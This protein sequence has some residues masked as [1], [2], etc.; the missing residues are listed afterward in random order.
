MLRTAV[1][2][3][4]LT[5]ASGAF[6]QSTS[7][8]LD[9]GGGMSHVDTMGPNGAMT[10]SN[11]MNIGGGIATCN[12]LDLSRPRRNNPTPDA[13][14][15][16]TDRPTLNFIGDLIARTKERSFQKKVSKMIADGDC[17]GAATFALFS[18]RDALSDQIHRDCLAKAYAEASKDL[19]TGATPAPEI[20]ANKQMIAGTPMTPVSG[21]ST[22]P[23]P[24][25]PMSLVSVRPIPIPDWVK[26]RDRVKASSDKTASVDKD[27]TGTE[28][29]VNYLGHT[30]LLDGPN[31]MTMGDIRS[32]FEN[33]WNDDPWIEYTSSGSGSIYSYNIKSAKHYSDHK[34]V[35]IKIDHSKDR[36]TKARTSKILY[37]I[38]CGKQT[39]RELQS[40][41]ND[42]SGIVLSL[43]NTPG[44]SNRIVPET[45]GSALY[46]EM[47]K[48]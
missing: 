8:T 17:R 37:E 36:T 29:T 46:D 40:V 41:E 47:C 19:V 43:Y 16:Q 7:T 15:P 39:L 20:V 48:I 33:A 13:N 38:K 10:S 6:G 45:V 11:C 14:D 21:A 1:A 27:S 23:I 42:A 44:A 25:S 3:A 31:G 12:T 2:I 30:F 24:P 28:Y 4:A 9:M 32:K 35:W 5:C 34:E 18:G 26:A 22:A